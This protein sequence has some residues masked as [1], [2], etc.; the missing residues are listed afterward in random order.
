MLPVVQALLQQVGCLKQTE[1]DLC[2]RLKELQAQDSSDA[3][4]KASMAK[5][6]SLASS[7]QNRQPLQSHSL[8][9]LHPAVA[10]CTAAGNLCSRTGQSPAAATSPQSDGSAAA[11]APHTRPQTAVT[12]ST[13]AAQAYQQ[14]AAAPQADL[15]QHMQQHSDINSQLQQ[16]LKELDAGFFKLRMQHRPSPSSSRPASPCPMSLKP[17]ITVQ[18][19][20]HGQLQHHAGPADGCEVWSRQQA[21][22]VLLLGIRMAAHLS[23]NRHL[24]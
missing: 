21:S 10:P 4:S 5:S 12:P 23:S 1:A 8:L 24:P 2:R 18:Q 3:G 6:L 14:P 22:N 9:A 19:G 20:Q 17:T 16:V 7:L 11:F 15:Q 13:S